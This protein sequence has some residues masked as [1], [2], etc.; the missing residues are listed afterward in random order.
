M[1]ESET[2][3]SNNIGSETTA[4]SPCYFSSILVMI[5]TGIS[6][7]GSLIFLFYKSQL[8]QYFPWYSAREM[9]GP[10]IH[11][12]A[13]NSNHKTSVSRKFILK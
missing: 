11:L 1:R 6:C 10:V 12:N 13:S 9:K 2:T 4:V 7:T 3:I 5:K 8:A